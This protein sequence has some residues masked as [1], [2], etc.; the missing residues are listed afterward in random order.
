VAITW[1]PAEEAI[2]WQLR[3]PRVVA[4][5]LVGAALACSGALLQGLFRNPLADPYVLGISA[6]AGLAATV[7]MALL[8]SGGATGAAAGVSL[9]RWAGF[10]PVPLAATAGG[11]FAVLVVYS[12]ARRGGR[13][14]PTRLLLAG[15]AVSSVCNAGST[16][17]IVLS[18]RLLLNWRSLLGWLVGGVVVSGWAQVGAAAPLIFLAVVAGWFLARW[19]DALLLGEE[20]AAQVGVPVEAAKVA[21]VLVASVLAG[22]AVA[23]AGLV[24]FVGL[25]VPQAVRLALGPGHRT[26]LP[27]ATLAGAIFLV[28][29]DL[30]A[31]VVLAPTELPVGVITALAGGPAFLWLLRRETANWRR[32]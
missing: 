18:E 20:G 17:L 15:F 28:L 10:G 12:L 2:L 26:L 19:L 7:A 29:A 32:G 21:V 13:V 27:C 31:R 25:L 3:F 4:A 30:L 8:A 6:G 9:L 14:P 16:L 23:L 24:G 11:F 1:P 5:A 22:A